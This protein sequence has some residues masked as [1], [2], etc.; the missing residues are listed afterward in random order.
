MAQRRPL[1]DTFLG[2]SPK[3]GTVP[4]FEESIDVRPP[5]KWTAESGPEEGWRQ[6]DTGGRWN[7]WAQQQGLSTTP[8]PR[9]RERRLDPLRTALG[10]NPDP[11]T[12][13]NPLQRWRDTPPR[14]GYSFAGPPGDRP[15]YLR[16]LGKGV[17]QDIA[18]WL[19]L[20]PAD[21]LVELPLAYATGGFAK[22]AQMLGRGRQWA[23]RQAARV[24]RHPL[25][26][27]LQTWKRGWERRGQELADVD[28]ERQQ[29]R[30]SFRR[31]FGPDAVENAQRRH[32]L[33]GRGFDDPSTY[34]EGLWELQDEIEDIRRGRTDPDFRNAADEFGR[35]E[36]ERLK[37]FERSAEREATARARYG[38]GPLASLKGQ[39][40]EPTI[41]PR[42]K[43]T[44]ELGFPIGA[45]R[46]PTTEDSILGKLYK[47]D[48]DQVDPER[49]IA[50]LS[51]INSRK[52][53]RPREPRTM[54]A[55][56][57]RISAETKKAQE[58]LTRSME[59]ESSNPA[60]E[61]VRYGAREILEANAG[62][63][64]RLGK[65]Y[66]EAQGVSPETADKIVGFLERMLRGGPRGRR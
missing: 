26:G 20:T 18:Q 11:K 47:E 50:E 32:A 39:K 27:G 38:G 60:M 7:Q 21:A 17:A 63:A 13:W 35:N 54:T 3:G 66:A 42:S 1:L 64:R 56:D 41:S 49:S 51:T 58:K 29:R 2:A 6:G 43:E 4:R 9:P 12:W 53:V 45:S 22:G 28:W 5:Q 15:A 34:D 14:R 57:R 10:T 59:V 8:L 44:D 30:G 46:R 62:E 24:G 52:G 33:A 36:Q 37:L 55:T 16:G 48:W 23:T 25:P 61:A 65:K 19:P 31:L 40:I